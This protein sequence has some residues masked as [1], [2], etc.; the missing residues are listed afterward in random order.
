[1][2]KLKDNHP[3]F[4]NTLS[5]FKPPNEKSREALNSQQVK[6]GSH[7]LNI[8]PELKDQAL[9]ISSYLVSSLLSA[10]SFA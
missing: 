7:Q 9:E 5:F 1:M 10:L 3:W 8:Q 2:K 4:V 6:I